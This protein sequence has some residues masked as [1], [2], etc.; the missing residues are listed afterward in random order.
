MGRHG[1]LLCRQLLLMSAVVGALE[2]TMWTGGMDLEKHVTP[3]TS[4]VWNMTLARR[5]NSFRVIF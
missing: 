4:T 5:F 2:H 3:W 1:Y